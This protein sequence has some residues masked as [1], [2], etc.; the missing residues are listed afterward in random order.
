LPRL[1]SFPFSVN[2]WREGF[3]RPSTVL[4]RS[5][6]RAGVVTAM[7]VTSDFQVLLAVS[8]GCHDVTGDGIIERYSATPDRDVPGHIPYV[9]T[10]SRR[11]FV[12]EAFTDETEVSRS[13]VSSFRLDTVMFSSKGGYP[14][15]VTFPLCLAPPLHCLCLRT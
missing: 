4:T 14:R 15:S 13:V 7:A 8:R 2:K 11:V 6:S 5:E 10:I 9:Y 3:T 12:T 1:L